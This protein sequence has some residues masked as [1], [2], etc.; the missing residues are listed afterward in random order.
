MPKNRITILSG[1][2]LAALLSVW[3]MQAGIA[4][5]ASSGLQV[6]SK[7]PVIGDSSPITLT[8]A[9]TIKRTL[10]SSTAIEI[11]TRNLDKDRAAIGEA[12]ASGGLNAGI[13]VT[14][15]HYD[16]QTVIAF[17]SMNIIVLDQD[18]LSGNVGVNLPIDIAGNIKA[19]KDLAHLQLLSDQFVL[20]ATVDNI[21]YQ[22]ETTY[23]NVLRATHQVSVAQAALKNAQ[24][25]QSISQ[26]QFSNGTGQKVDLLRANTQVAVADKNLIQAKNDLA[27]AKVNLNDIVGLPLNTQVEVEDVRG[28]TSGIL[29][30]SEKSTG[31]NPAVPDNFFKASADDIN[32][33]DL[34]KSIDSA[35]KSRAELKEDLVNLQ[36]AEKAVKLAHSSLDPTLTLSA[37]FVGNANDTMETPRQKIGEIGATLNIPV[38]DSGY[39]REK[40]RESRDNAQNAKSLYDSHVTDVGREVRQAYL[41]LQNAAQQIDAADTALLQAI[42]ARE[43]AQTRYE[44]GVGLYIEVTD[45]E[46]A[47]SQSETNQVNSVYNYFIAKAEFKRALGQIGKVTSQSDSSVKIAK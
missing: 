14:G 44:N 28:V 42:A 16:E 3:G 43:L 29:I 24:T 12:N 5:S 13:S 9:D 32:Q 11:T 41:N 30:D 45:S 38:Y 26:D 7:A 20:E 21:I 1:A 46:Q 25:Q 27:L 23:Y 4:Q 31:A 36:A 6:I 35:I 19:T 47:L 2:S 37:A 8:L 15:T 10:S 40:T 18:M 39:A 22:T 33:I 34:D 17:G